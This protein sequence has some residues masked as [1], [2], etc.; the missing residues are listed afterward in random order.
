MK[1]NIYDLLIIFIFL[2]FLVLMIV[3]SDS[4][5][6]IVLYGIKIWKENIFTSLFP[7]FIISDL[8]INYGF[9]DLIGELFK[10]I[11]SKLSLPGES[12]FVVITSIFSGFPSSS[13][14]IKEL[15]DNKK[16]SIKNAEYL[17]SFTHYPNPLFVMGIVS[18]SVLH[19][20]V[21]GIIVYIS[22]ILGS[23]ILAIF[24]RDKNSIYTTNINIRK[25]LEL[26]HIKNKSNNFIKILT[27]SIIKTINTLMLLLGII[28]TFLILTTVLSNILNLNIYYKTII[29]GILEMTSGINNIKILPIPLIIKSCLI[30]FFICFGGISIH[31]QIMSILSDYNIHYNKYFICR[32]LHSVIST[33]INIILTSIFIT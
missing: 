32:I 3:F 21:S 11:M 13:K 17:L 14:Y 4:V 31:L 23:F 12:S 16:I 7:F 29:S 6:K 33:C 10:K 20:K 27:D 28:T 25:T 26:I 1:K 19:N 15:L 30:T 2:S 9:I 18:E 5:I 24:L 8:L 22:I